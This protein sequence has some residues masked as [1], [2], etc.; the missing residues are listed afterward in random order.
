MKTVAATLVL[1]L[2]AATSQGQDEAKK[3]IEQINKHYAN[4]H[5]CTVTLTMD[6]EFPNGAPFGLGNLDQTSHASV[7]KPNSFA[8]WPSEK[9]SPMGMPK[10]QVLCD[11]RQLI[12]ALPEASV[13]SIEEAP[14]KLADLITTPDPDA[15][16][17]AHAWDMVA[18]SQLVIDL[19][20]GVTDKGLL[21]MLADA[22]YKGLQGKDA[23][24]RHV[25][26]A[27]EKNPVTE[28]ETKLEVFVAPG[29]AA[30]VTAIKPQLDEVQTQMM[31]DM[32]I[33][34]RFDNWKAVDALPD[35][36]IFQPKDGWKKVDN[37]LEAALG[38][39]MDED[40]APPQELDMDHPAVDVGA[41]APAFS[42]R[43]LDD[44]TF[45]LADY[46]GKVVVLDFWATW[47]GP[48]VA[49]LPTVT[50]VT[51]EYADKG[52][53]FTAVN[54]RE[55]PDHVRTFMA[56]KK[57]NFNVAM[58]SDGAIANLY[59]VTGIPHSVIID[60]TGVVRHV[61]VGF[62]G[63]E[64]YEAQLRQELDQLLKD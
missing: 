1:S 22:E 23:D 60:K 50:K 8:F 40:D 48:C 47:C 17:P 54:L 16:L 38:G 18:G 9:P 42:L 4:L 35:T 55:A 43:T 59:G 53:V 6:V 28:E 2:I 32:T 58:D 26:L 41:V 45:T 13:Y 29:E 31:G 27:V 12:S 49:G 63:A 56:D 14:E 15:M 62:G 5:G 21:K 51:S 34:L 37:V 52:V 33:T 61:H 20:S 64:Q 30:W 57:W 44:K 7:V 3:V 39:M 10:V 19:M 11:G 36:A 24:A 46:K 25:F